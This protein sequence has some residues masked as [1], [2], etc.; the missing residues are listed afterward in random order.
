MRWSYIDTL[1]R[2]SRKTKVIRFWVDREPNEHS[3]L[4]M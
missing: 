2:I 3:G 4:K 1:K